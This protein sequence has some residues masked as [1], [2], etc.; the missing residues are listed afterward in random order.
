MEVKQLRL[1]ENED[2]QEIVDKKVA[3]L[4]AQRVLTEMWVHVDMDCFY[5]SVEIRDNPSLK[6]KPVA[7][8]SNSM[9]S[10][11]SYEVRGRFIKF[12]HSLSL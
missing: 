11:A 6:G 9:L 3:A 7:V 5:A 2:F 4:E 8:G 12:A 1:S 10:T